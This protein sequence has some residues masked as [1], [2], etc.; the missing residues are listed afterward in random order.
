MDEVKLVH[1]FGAPE[2][3]SWEIEDGNWWQDKPLRKIMSRN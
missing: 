1:A 3:W 2:D